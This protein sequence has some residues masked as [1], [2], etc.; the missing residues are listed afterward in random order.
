[1]KPSALSIILTLVFFPIIQSQAQEPTGTITGIVLDRDS[2]QILP[3]ANVVLHEAEEFK[4]TTSD[5][6]GRFEL[7]NVP[8]GRVSLQVSYLGYETRRL[9]NLNL[10]SGREL[11]LEIELSPAALEAGK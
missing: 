11:Q 3:G 6:N 1:M 4:G 9:S 5:A 2:R 7:Q 10:T 8:V